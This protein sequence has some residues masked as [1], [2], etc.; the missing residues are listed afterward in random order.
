[1][2]DNQDLPSFDSIYTHLTTTHGFTVIPRKSPQPHER[3]T[4][5]AI[6]ELSI[7]PTLE[8]LLHILNSDLPSAHFL[9]RH[10]QNA[11]AWEGMYIHGLL[12]R[13]EGDME[14]AKAWYGDVAHSE[15]FQYA[16]PEGLEKARSFLDDVKAVKDSPTCPQDLQQLSRQEI[17]RL[18]EWCKRRFGVA[19]LEDATEAWVEPGEKHREMAAKMVGRGFPDV[20]ANG[21][22][23]A[24]Y[25]YKWQ[26]LDSGTSTSAPVWG[27]VA[28][29]LNAERAAVGKSPAGF[30]QTVLHQHREVFHDIRSG[31]N[32]G[33]DTDGFAAV[34]G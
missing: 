31:S 21:A 33:C 30:I 20:R 6:A 19:R 18:A 23:F 24:D 25:W 28:V 10:M 22:N 13:V 14:N 32:Q 5:H 9:C 11:P 2:S 4:S 8:A 17:D 29:L 12:H 27:S 3:A 7:H 15:C 34:E 16:W 26:I 1:M